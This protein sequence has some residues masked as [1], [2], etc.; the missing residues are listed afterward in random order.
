MEKIELYDIDLKNF[1]ESSAVYS[2]KVG[3][4]F[5]EMIDAPAI[6]NGNLDV[7]VIIKKNIGYFD[8]RFQIEGVVEGVCDRCL[9]SLDVEVETEDTLKVKLGIEYDDSNDD[10]LIIPEYEGVI[11]IA[12]YIYEFALLSLP[13]RIVHNEGECNEEMIESLNHVLTTEIHEG[14][15]ED[16]FDDESADSSEVGQITDPRWDALKKILNNN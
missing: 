1:K 15:D 11:N 12:W 2:Y 7:R 8:F 16:E 10:I 3:H 13:Y 5:F 6:K 14:D 9:D 4:D